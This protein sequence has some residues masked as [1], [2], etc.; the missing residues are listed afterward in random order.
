MGGKYHS[1]CTGN[2]SV[3]MLSVWKRMGQL[4]CL[5]TFGPL[6]ELW[7][8]FVRW[9]SHHHI[10]CQPL[11]AVKCWLCLSMQA[12]VQLGSIPYVFLKKNPK[13]LGRGICVHIYAGGEAVV[14]SACL[15]LE[16]PSCPGPPLHAQPPCPSRA[17][18]A[19]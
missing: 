5:F 6:G 16:Q 9:E 3:E 18:A 14:C 12:S 1:I 19:L 13:C 17:E 11:T 10:S 7:W 15:P 8:G 4:Q 2:E